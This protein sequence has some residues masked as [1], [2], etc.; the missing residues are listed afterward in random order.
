MY[1]KQDLGVSACPVKVAVVTVMYILICSYFEL[2][3]FF[4]RE[5]V[6]LKN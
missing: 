5:V 6:L 3:Q 1:F 4:V 2:N